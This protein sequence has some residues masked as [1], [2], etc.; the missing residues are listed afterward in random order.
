M[1]LM[2]LLEMLEMTDDIEKVL[3]W[4]L[5]SNCYP[6]VPEE[7]VPLCAE[8]IRVVRMKTDSEEKTVLQ[9]PEGFFYKDVEKTVDAETVISA[10][11]LEGFLMEDEYENED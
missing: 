7:Y 6:P 8:A 1:G 4:H 11:H 2:S 3:H 9:L 5:T 10:F